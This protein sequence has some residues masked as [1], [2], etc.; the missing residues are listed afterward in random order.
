MLSFIKSLARRLPALLAMILLVIMCA[1]AIAAPRIAPLADAQQ[2]LSRRLEPPGWR[3]ESGRLF[4]AG[5][6]QLGRDLGPRLIHGS[7]VSLAV[8][9]TAVAIGGGFG[10]AI[11]IASGYLGG[12]FDL[13]VQF[14]TCASLS[15]FLRLFLK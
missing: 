4:V 15:R 2:D 8:A 3:D 13:L 10:L 11:G 6:D 5:T 12:K 7:R 14:V 1:M 9:G